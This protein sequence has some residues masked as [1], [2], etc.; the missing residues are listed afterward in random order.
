M[1]GIAA[2]YIVMLAIYYSNAWGSQ[3]LPFMSTSLRSA[4]GSSYPTAEVFT[5]GVLNETALAEHGMLLNPKP[6]R[7]LPT[8]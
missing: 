8:S 5:G 2:C 3:S 7:G 6:E 4:D 1:A